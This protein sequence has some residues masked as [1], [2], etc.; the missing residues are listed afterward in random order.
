VLKYAATYTACSV[1]S[2][3]IQ[4]EKDVYEEWYS[5]IVKRLRDA[6][7]GMAV[8]TDIIVG[9]PGETERDFNDTMSLLEEIEFESAF[10]FKFS[11][12][13]GTPA[14][15]CPADEIVDDETSGRRLSLLQSFQRDVTMKKNRA[16]VGHIEEVLAEGAS[17][18]DPEILTGRTS[19]NRIAHFKGSS[20]L[21]GKILKVRITEGLFNSLRGELSV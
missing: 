9:Y 20:V 19:H 6:A 11:P 7:P 18:N 2:N 4:D 1:W 15:A 13:P 21:S 16:R 3:A 17:K 8:S 14:A 12:R 5:D 10:S